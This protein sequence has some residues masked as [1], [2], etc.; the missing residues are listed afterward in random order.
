[1][2]VEYTGFEGLFLL[3]PNR[4]EDTRGF[5][6]ESFNKEKLKKLTGFIGE[7]VQDNQSHSS[8]GVLRG[9]HFQTGEYAQTKLVRVL[10]GRVLDVAFD[11]RKNLKTYGQAYSVELSEENGLQLLIPRGFAHGL[12]VLS[13]VADFFY[14]CDN[15]YSPKH[16]SGLHYKS[17]GVQWPLDED[18]IIISDKDLVLPKFEF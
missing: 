4:F 13:D 8:F 3:K 5:F 1:M 7:F 2:E 9:M 14:K 6:F 18:K 15:Y 11:M 17:I 12:A 10:K 16:E